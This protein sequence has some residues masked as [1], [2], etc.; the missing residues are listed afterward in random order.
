MIASASWTA[1]QCLATV[2]RRVLIVWIFNNTSKSVFAAILFHAIVNV[3]DFMFP[4][5]GS[6][7]NPEVFAIII[8]VVVA[9]VVTGW[10]PGTL[11]RHR[12]RDEI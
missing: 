12:L 8:L 7:Y 3:C 6:D 1:W 11:A 5:Y 9:I 10:G 2:G 4:N